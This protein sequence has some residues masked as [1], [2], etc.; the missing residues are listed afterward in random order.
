MVA[1][2]DVRTGEKTVL[3]YLTKPL[4]RMRQS[5]LRER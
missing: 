4:T 2:V 5:A 3:G 1:D